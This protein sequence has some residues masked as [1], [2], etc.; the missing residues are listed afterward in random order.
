MF[1]ACVE[2]GL[3]L[4]CHNCATSLLDKGVNSQIIKFILGHKSPAS[5]NAYLSVD[6]IRLKQCTLSIE[7]FPLRKEV[8]S[9]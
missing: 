6:L 9:I 8:L 1:R 7:H 3:H 2:I 5:L 4:F